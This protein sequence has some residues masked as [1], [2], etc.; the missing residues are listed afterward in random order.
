[1]PNHDTRSEGTGHP[2]GRRAFIQTTARLAAL[3]G[4]GPILAA[5]GQASS[6]PPA[7][8]STAPVVSAAAKPSASAPAAAAASSA[9]SA[10]P[11]V[12]GALTTIRYGAGVPPP[13]SDAGLLLADS[14]GWFKEQGINLDTQ[15][16]PNAI[17]MI[18][19]LGTNQLDA[20]GGAPSSG[21]FNAVLRGVDIAIVADKAS[22]TPGHGYQGIVIRKERMDSGTFH[23]AADLKGLKIGVSS[24]GRAIVDLLKQ[25]GLTVK[26]VDLVIIKFPDMAPALVNGSLDAAQPLE[27]YL[28]Q[29]IEKGIA[30]LFQR[31]DKYS[32]GLQA[33][34]IFF[35]P[36]LLK[37]TDLATRFMTAYLK[38]VRLYNDAFDKNDAK[39]RADVIDTLSQ[40]TALKDKRLYEKVV[41]P[42]LDPNG[43]VNIDDLASQQQ[44]FMSIGEQKQAIDMNKLVDLS[45][46]QAAAAELGPYTSAKSS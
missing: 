3:A 39:A 22:I 29:E 42:G 40:R 4:V 31:I 18:A 20:G 5:C 14:K 12:S 13:V 46:A 10:K 23:S 38:G 37:N 45:F 17:E 8:P 34:V 36:N 1:M 33:G 25:G 35:S 19:P 30:V 43:K 28:T 27:P 21:L 11:T 2:V 9:S 6:A 7:A 41:M 15:A 16:F 32:P 44:Y 24:S 26:D